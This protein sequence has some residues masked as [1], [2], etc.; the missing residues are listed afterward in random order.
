MEAFVQDGTVLWSGVTGKNGDEHDSVYFTE[1]SHT[2]PSTLDDSDAARLISANTEILR[3]VGMRDGM[4]HAEYRL[5]DRGV[6]LMEVAARL[7]GD[8]ITFLWELSTGVP[9]E[10]VM[11]DLALG[12]PASYPAPRRRTRQHFLDHAHGVLTDVTADGIPVVWPGVNDR[13][14]TFTPLPIA[15]PAD[16]HAVLV[17]R[18]PATCSARRSTRVT[19]R[20]P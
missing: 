12:V 18:L 3:R 11:I 13:W 19:G 20:R 2:C 10:P 4:T 7:P 14:P 1:T 16:G 6:V 17:G 9:V 5:T 8:A 15:A